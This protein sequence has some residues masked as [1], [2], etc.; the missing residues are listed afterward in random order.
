MATSHH[1][2]SSRAQAAGNFTLRAVAAACWLAG[3]FALPAHAQ[4]A[5]A[6]GDVLRETNRQQPAVPRPDPQLPTAQ[7]VRPQLAQPGGFKTVVNGF[8][9]TGNA[10]IKETDL[11]LLLLDNL[12]KE[13]TF[14]D[15]QKAADAISNYYRAQGFFVARAYLP[16]QEIQGGII[17]IAVLEGHVGKSVAKIGGT[18]RTKPEV[19]QR[20]LDANVQ[21]GSIVQE[22]TLERA[23]LLANDLPNMAASISLDPGAQTGQTDVTLEVTEGR[24]ITGSVDADNYGNRFTGQNR[25]GATLNLNSPLG[26]GDLLSVRLMKSNE[27]LDFGRVLYQVPVGSLGTR[28]GASFS[29]VNFEVCCQTGL[30]PAGR[31]TIAS[32]YALHPIA[33]SRD[34]SWYANASFDDKESVNDPGIGA[35]RRR[36]IDLFTVGSSIEARDSLMGGGFTFGNVSLAHGRLGIDDPTDSSTDATGARAAGSFS[37][38]GLQ[39]ARTQRL[40]DR[41]SLYGGMNAQYASKNL[42]A[43]EKFS[44]GGAQGV[45]GYP[46]GEASGD[47]GYIAQVELRADLPIDAGGTLWQAFLFADYGSIRLN[48]ENFAAGAGTVNA[49][50]LG[51][52]GLGLN[53][54]KAGLFQIRAMWAHKAGDNPGRNIVTGTDSDGKSG[55]SR[56]WF[57]AVTQF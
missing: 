27:E 42:D 8:R 54:A 31:G 20:L 32:L 44:L 51:S 33:R 55:S 3:T 24:L 53:V 17:E 26:L 50:S 2:D 28:V 47:Q 16:Q 22:K 15:L 21:P 56:F 34:F 46:A 57:Q 45:R 30:A 4:Q 39:I 7:P 35:A 10:S 14:N 37:K 23:A 52:W 19:V 48:R 6:A 9:I 43:M 1:S 18:A 36:D 13:N 29:R 40:S 12:G 25:V 38:L 11:Q 41:F 49:Y 5:P